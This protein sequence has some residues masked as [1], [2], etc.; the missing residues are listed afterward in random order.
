MNR[1]WVRGMRM[2]A[3]I[4][5]VF[6][7][8]VSCASSDS[9]PKA[10]DSCTGGGTCQDAKVQLLCIG[11]KL[12]AGACK[13]PKGCTTAGDTS[14]CDLT[15]AD[16]G[17]VCTS[18]GEGKGGCS[19]DKK[20]LLLCKA[21]KMVVER[22]CSGTPCD[23]SGTEIACGS[24]LGDAC[25]GDGFRCAPDKKALLKCAAGKYVVDSL[26]KGPAG[27]APKDGKAN[28]DTTIAEVGDPCPASDKDFGAC[29]ADGS[30]YVKCDGT[31]Y[32][33]IAVCQAPLKCDLPSL[34]CK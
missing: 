26:C 33:E 5:V 12:V 11:G 23:S 6:G 34:S 10:G 9:A 4:A 24:A 8:V 30:K 3:S 28:C 17:D 14:T 29:S 13:G 21:G 7:T 31:K 15:I 32:V 25:N 19:T 27:C 2:W 16:A 1:A 18:S 20:S 22:G